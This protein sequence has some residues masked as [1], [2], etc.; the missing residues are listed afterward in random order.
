MLGLVL[1]VVT[2]QNVPA[3]SH[4]DPHSGAWSYSGSHG[5]GED[6]WWE[7]WAGCSGRRQS[8]IPITTSQVERLPP[9]FLKAWQPAGAS[10]AH[11]WLNETGHD[12]RLFLN[13]LDMIIVG[14]SFDYVMKVDNF[15]FHTPSEHMIDGVEH[16][17]ELHIV[18]SAADD[19]AYEVSGHYGHVVVGILYEYHASVRDPLLTQ[20]LKVF[21]N[22][23]KPAEDYFVQVRPDLELS[24]DFYEYE[25]SLTTPPCTE[26][27]H[28]L[29]ASRPRLAAQDQ[30]DAIRS[31]LLPLSSIGNRRDPQAP[32]GRKVY[33]RYYSEDDIC[34][35]VCEY[36][37]KIGVPA[38]SPAVVR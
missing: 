28:W 20:L 3:G 25:G 35:D 37:T 26:A 32:N 5:L 34:D 7:E 6:Y 31:R 16:P 23:T 11:V 21:S 14:S 27:V 1:C 36:G 29:L 33:R 9:G 12:L 22:Q 8:P 30:I 38:Q 19:A 18:T 24:G 2:A 15:H 13:E 4:P 17:L 10:G